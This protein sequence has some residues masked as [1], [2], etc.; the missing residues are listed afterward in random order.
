MDSN[1]EQL[2]GS[3]RHPSNEYILNGPKPGLVPFMV[4]SKNHTD[5]GSMLTTANENAAV[6]DDKRRRY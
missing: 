5:L 2:L 1:E 4:G 6:E 3:K